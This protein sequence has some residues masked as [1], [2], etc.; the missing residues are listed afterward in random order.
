MAL[1][2]SIIHTKRSTAISR[3]TVN[4]D[5]YET[6]DPNET[7]QIFND[8]FV[9]IGESIAKK[10][11]TMNDN[12]NFKKFLKNFLFQSIVL[13]FPQLIEIF[14]II[15]SLNIKHAVAYDICLSFRFF[16]V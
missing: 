6:N 4:V 5:S 1:I 12:V 11:K 7:S 16:Y 9:K 2:N 3:L 10:A 14:N 8:Y 15:K 13:E